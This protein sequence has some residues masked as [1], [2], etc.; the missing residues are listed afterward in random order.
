MN[1]GKPLWSEGVMIVSEIHR[2]HELS[3]GS[4]RARSINDIVTATAIPH[5]SKFLKELELV[6]S[7]HNTYKNS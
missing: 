4:A 7:D 5:A 1:N 3:N 6:V 2:A